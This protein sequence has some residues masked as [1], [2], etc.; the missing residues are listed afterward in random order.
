MALLLTI[1]SFLFFLSSIRA[2]PIVYGIDGSEQQFLPSDDEGGPYYNNR[3]VKRYVEPLTDANDYL[4]A[5]VRLGQ[6]RPLLDK[7]HLMAQHTDR[8]IARLTHFLA[9][10]QRIEHRDDERVHAALHTLLMSDLNTASCDELAYAA[11]GAMQWL[12]D[13]HCSYRVRGTTP[14]RDEVRIIQ[15]VVDRP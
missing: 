10:I 4:K 7:Q 15:P 1:L 8:A 11:S 13:I 14:P 2:R 12:N 3:L 6:L 5:V 9:F